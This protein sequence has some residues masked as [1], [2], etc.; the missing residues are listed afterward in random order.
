ME[1]KHSKHVENGRLSPGS[2]ANVLGRLLTNEKKHCFKE[3]KERTRSRFFLSIDLARS[4]LDLCE[5]I[6]KRRIKR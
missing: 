2:S 3:E 5:N 4:R 6:E 1:N